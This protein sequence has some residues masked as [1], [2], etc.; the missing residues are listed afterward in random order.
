MPRYVRNALACPKSGSAANSCGNL[1]GITIPTQSVPAATS[2]TGGKVADAKARHRLERNVHE[3]AALIATEAGRQGPAAETAVGWVVVNR[4]K[5]NKA[6][7]VDQVW[8]P[9]FRHG[10]APHA[11]QLATARGILGGTIL[12]PTSGSTHFYTPQAM[13]KAGDATK[14]RDIG[15]GLETVPGVVDDDGN[16]VQNYQPGWVSG[17]TQQTVTGVAESV[18][19]FYRQGGQGHVR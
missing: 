8:S 17:M 16:T 9:A 19:K 4:M 1:I 5:R 15:G 2:A 10:K 11:S 18:F 12:D 7:A 14:N 3:L 6:T 13:P